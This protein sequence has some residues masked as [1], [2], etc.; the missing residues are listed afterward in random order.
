MTPIHPLNAP[1]SITDSTIYITDAAVNRLLILKQEEKE[2]GQNPSFFRISVLSG[3][4]SGFQ[5]KFDLTS[6]I[7]LQD[8]IFKGEEVSLVTDPISYEFLKNVT[9]DYVQ[10]LMG[11]AFTLKNPNAATSCGC[12]NSFGL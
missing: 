12:G 2:K 7:D 5:Y 4:C 6:S 9:L 10:D 1:D 11:A 3:G 8:L